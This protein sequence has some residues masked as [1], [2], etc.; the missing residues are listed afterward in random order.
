MCIKLVV[1]SQLLIGT[2]IGADVGGACPERQLLILY[3]PLLQNML[4]ILERLVYQNT[5]F[6]LQFYM[7]VSL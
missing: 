1:W 5:F 3:T 4:H 6:M 2:S 7:S